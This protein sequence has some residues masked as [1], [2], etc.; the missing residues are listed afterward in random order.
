MTSSLDNPNVKR[1]TVPHL[2]GIDV[3]YQ[4]PTK[5]NPKLPTLVLVNRCVPVASRTKTCSWFLLRGGSVEK[6]EISG[7]WLILDY[8]VAISQK[9]IIN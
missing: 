8:R 1:V 2:G 5:Y 7:L 6:A 3:G 9:W 4:M